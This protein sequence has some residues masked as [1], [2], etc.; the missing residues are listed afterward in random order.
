MS[1]PL[2]QF[3]KEFSDDRFATAKAA[4]AR[5]EQW[6]I[7]STAHAWADGREEVVHARGFEEGHALAL[8]AA[9]AELANCRAECDARL[10]AL[11][12]IYSRAAAEQL[13]SAID[14]GLARL[15]ATLTDQLACALLPVLRHVMDEASVRELVA[16]MRTLLDECT[17]TLEISGPRHMLERI[18]RNFEEQHIDFAS[19]S[20]PR[21][22]FDFDEQ[23]PVRVR[24]GNTSI[25]TRVHEWAD[26]ITR[27]VG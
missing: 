11:E 27:Q 24:M 26:R 15:Y 22:R 5:T 19:T 25:E 7:G 13:A 6:P 16:E 2:I 23:S 10:Q 9:A 21:V 3:L 18:W 4:P 12:E 20:A 1:R 14:A 8:A 17:I